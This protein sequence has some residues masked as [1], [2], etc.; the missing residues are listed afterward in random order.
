MAI[1]AFLDFSKATTVPK[2]VKGESNDEM[3]KDT[4]HVKTFTFA[5]NQKGTAPTGLG[6]GA[7]KAE[8]DDFEFTIDTQRGSAEL[9]KHC[10]KGSH[11]DM[12]FLHVRK[13]G[14]AHVE[15][16]RYGFSSCIISNYSTSGDEESTDTVKFNYARVYTRYIVQKNDGTLDTANDSK[17][18]W[19]LKA[20][21]DYEADGPGFLAQGGEQK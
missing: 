13:A 10:A 19:D 7:G 16:L 4:F 3:F 21:N 18:G 15:F 12:V 6:L 5:I 17:G 14:G 1:D 11:F 20:N 8:F 9:L 2:K